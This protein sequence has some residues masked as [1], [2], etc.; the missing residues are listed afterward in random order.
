MECQQRQDHKRW[1]DSLATRESEVYF[2]VS[3]CPPTLEGVLENRTQELNCGH[4][5]KCVRTRL[6]LLAVGCDHTGAFGTSRVSAD[7]L[8]KII[9]IDS[10]R[11]LRLY[12]DLLVPLE[13][14]GL[15]DVCKLLRSKIDQFYDSKIMA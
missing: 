12:E 14:R 2:G 3:A 9:E 11:E 7:L 6:Q 8:E 4:C 10:T 1:L 5:E 13:A 15:G